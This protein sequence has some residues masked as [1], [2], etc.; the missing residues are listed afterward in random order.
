MQETNDPTES[1]IGQPHPRNPVGDSR[2]WHRRAD[3]RQWHRRP[4]AASDKEG[5]IG[6]GC[7]EGTPSHRFAL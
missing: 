6:H 4:E 1:P 3:S 2:A 7:A 5:V